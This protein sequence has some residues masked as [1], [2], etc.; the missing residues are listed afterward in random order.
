MCT[1]INE[2]VGYHLFG[3]TL[4]LEYSLS[5]RAV[6][7]PRRFKLD[8]IHE[9]DMAEHSAMVGIA[10]VS[11]GRPL[12]YD[13]IN[14]SGLG[15]AG[16]NFGGS[17]VYL[18][19]RKGFFNVASFE[20]IPWVLGQCKDLAEAI[21]LL[22]GT[23]LTHDSV[24]KALPAT[25]M[26]W[27]IADKTGAVA[28]EPTFDGLKITK[29]PFGVLTNEPP[30]EYH[31]TNVKNYTSLSPLP[32]KNS[33]CPDVDLPPYSRGMGAIGLPGDYSSASRFVRATF[34]KSHTLPESEKQAAINR[35]FRIADTV[36][37]PRGC[38]V[39]DEGRAVSTVYT[40]CA[41][42]DEL[43]Y[44]FSSYDSRGLKRIQMSDANIDSD[45]LC[46]IEI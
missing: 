33:L 36:S 12:Y 45:G 38:I 11:E 10:H 18:P 40:S 30:I 3:R 14:E 24:S 41:D 27:L 35:F 7:T 37:V 39:T 15:A 32:P 16:L 42:T 25:P 13:A 34:V 5:E 21:E 44:Y 1:A 22:R 29:N 6:I 2:T 28:A 19:Y 26:H 43:T 46:S 23:N 17:A 4:D 8:F 9:K 31:L 20:L